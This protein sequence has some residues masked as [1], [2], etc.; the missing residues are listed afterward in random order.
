MTLAVI[1]VLI[2]PLQILL[3]MLPA[4]L[5]ALFGLLVSMLKPSAIRQ[6]LK[7]LW[8]LKIQVL[9]LVVLVVC[10]RYV[11][12]KIELRGAT[13]RFEGGA[14]ETGGDWS[15]FRGNSARTGHVPGSADPASGGINWAF[16]REGESYLEFPCS[17]RQP[18]LPQYRAH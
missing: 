16:H 3:A 8:R 10:V 13:Q 17:G 14:A 18:C 2:G 1:P 11:G 12:A 9:V 15:T 6:F 7:L 4:I 5:A